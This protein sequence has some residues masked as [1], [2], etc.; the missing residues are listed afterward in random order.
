MRVIRSVLSGNVGRGMRAAKLLHIIHSLNDNDMHQ[1]RI[2]RE[3][4]RLQLVGRWVHTTRRELISPS[5]SSAQ[6][7]RK[8]LTSLLCNLLISS[9]DR[10]KKPQCRQIA[11]LL[12]VNWLH[13]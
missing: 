8:P 12:S 1:L 10:Q 9:T 11:I 3:R 5:G 4:P 7:G 2:G 6:V 13:L